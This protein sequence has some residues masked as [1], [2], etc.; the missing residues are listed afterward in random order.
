[1]ASPLTQERTH[2][3]LALMGLA[4]ADHASDALA[5]F[6]HMHLI[7]TLREQ[8]GLLTMDRRPKADP[9]ALALAT[10]GAGGRTS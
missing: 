1:V 9:A 7:D 10:R 2:D 5:G 6:C 8:Y 3:V 4:K